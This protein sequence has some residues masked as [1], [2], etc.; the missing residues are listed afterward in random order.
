MKVILL[1][2]PSWKLFSPKLHLAL[3][4]LYMAGELRQAG[5]EVEVM[6]CHSVTSC[7]PDDRSKLI[8]H[9]EKLKPCDIVGLSAT[10]G[11]AHYGQMLAEAWPAKIKI[12]GGPHVTHIFQ[13]PH[14][15]FK[16]QKY[17]RGWDYLMHGECELAFV[18]FVRA[19]SEGRDPKKSNIPG[20]IWWDALGL[21]QMPAPHEPDV[22]KAAGPAFDLWTE[23][24]A[25]GAMSIPGAKGHQ[26]DLTQQ[27]TS[28]LYTSRG[29]PYGCNFCADAR[30]KLREETLEQIE[31]QTKQLAEMGITGI[32]FQDDTFTIR[33]KRAMAIADIMHDYGMI[34]RGT[35]RVNLINPELF[36][37]FQK[38][39]CT[40]LAFG[41]EHASAKMLKAMEKGTTPEKNE[42]GIKMAWDAGITP[43]S[44]LIIGFPGETEDTLKEMEEWVLRVRPGAITLSLFT[45]YPGSA[46]WNNPEKF[47]ITIPDDAF[48]K[49]WQVGGEYDPANMLI[50]IPTMSKW[51]LWQHRQRLTKVFENEIGHLDR[52]L[53]HGNV[54]TFVPESSGMMTDNVM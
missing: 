7:D 54:G 5:F 3:G 47:G 46:V 39:G 45:P 19:V 30:T 4:I 42:I 11:N 50:D 40:E 8:I 26:L 36:R 25:K 22:T 43:R 34:W 33:E 44:F 18:D 23:G 24:F 10:T 41:V 9:H 35:T 32:R 29:C 52:T 37:Y 12:L 27:Y 6:D 38:K 51:E 15:R 28:S 14:A 17:F 1:D 31:A 20:L 21:H 13:G 49:F 16:Q 48:D 53:M 2:S